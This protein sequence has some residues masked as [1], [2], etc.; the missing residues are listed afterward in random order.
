MP[1]RQSQEDT[2]VSCYDEKSSQIKLFS[3]NS[4]SNIHNFPV[5]DKFLDLCHLDTNDNRKLVGL[6]ENSLSIFAI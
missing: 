3:V 5:K 1:S 4:G 2:L 6:S